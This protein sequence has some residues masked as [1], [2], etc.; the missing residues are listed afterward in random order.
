VAGVSFE[1]ALRAVEQRL[2]ER[3]AEHSRAV[4]QTAAELAAAYGVDVQAA[5]LAGLLHDWSREEDDEKLLAD[6]RA[7]GIEVEG[8]D[9]TVPYLLHAYTGAVELK[10]AFPEISEEVVRAVSRHTLG[11]EDMSDL[12]MVVY[13]ADMIEPS[14]TFE[15]ADE[16]R[17][18]VGLVDLSELFV[19]AYGHSLTH[20][21]EKRRHLHPRTV[22]VWNAAVDALRSA[23][24]ETE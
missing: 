10:A 21:I 4:A 5:R 18:A 20:V 16:L 15:G 6:A 13:V 9:E 1:A 2:G 12:D 14:R 24:Q 3:S 23:H 8:V 22:L 11:A 17:D 19:R 7:A